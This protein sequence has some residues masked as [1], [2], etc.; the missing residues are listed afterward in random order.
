MLELMVFALGEELCWGFEGIGKRFVVNGL[1]TRARRR[2]GESQV[3]QGDAL[4][5]PQLPVLEGVNRVLAMC[6]QMWWPI[7][8]SSHTTYRRQKPWTV[9]GESLD[10]DKTACAILDIF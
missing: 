7:Q 8:S 2:S 1:P 3:A 5:V 9:S 6:A 4:K 10:I